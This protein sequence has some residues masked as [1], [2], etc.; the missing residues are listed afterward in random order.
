M[1]CTGKM[2]NTFGKLFRLSMKGLRKADR[3]DWRFLLLSMNILK[4]TSG[5]GISELFKRYN[6]LIIKLNLQGKFY[7]QMEIN[8]ILFLTLPTHLEHRITTIRD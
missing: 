6:K 1:W 3:K 5:E 2:T 8:K 4:S 7:T